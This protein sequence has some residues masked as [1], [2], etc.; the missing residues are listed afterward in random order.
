MGRQEGAGLFAWAGAHT[1]GPREPGELHCGKG[2]ACG[3][4]GP[5]APSAMGRCVGS[6][7]SRPAT[8]LGGWVA[9]KGAHVTGAACRPGTSRKPLSLTCRGGGRCLPS[10]GSSA[11][12]PRQPSRDICAMGLLGGLGCSARTGLGA[13]RLDRPRQDPPPPR[14]SARRSGRGA[15]CAWGAGWRGRGSRPARAVFFRLLFVSASFNWAIPCRVL[16]P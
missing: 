8:W 10:P 2:A 9:G 1:G 16:V 6:G 7:D 11:R 5:P 15:Q 13:E 3:W 4:P 12:R 14:D